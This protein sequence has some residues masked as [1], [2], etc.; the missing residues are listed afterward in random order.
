M[1]CYFRSFGTVGNAATTTHPPAAAAYVTRLASEYKR[2]FAE[3]RRLSKSI[4]HRMATLSSN[5]AVLHQFYHTFCICATCHGIYHT[6]YEETLIIRTPPL[7]PTTATTDDAA[8]QTARS[9]TEEE[10]C[11]RQDTTAPQFMCIHCWN[12]RAR[13]QQDE[14]PQPPQHQTQT[15]QQKDN[16]IDPVIIQNHPHA[17]TRSTL[18]K[19]N[20]IPT[21][22][23]TR[24][25]ELSASSGVRS[26]KKPGRPSLLLSSSL[27]S[28]ELQTTTPATMNSQPKSCVP[29]LVR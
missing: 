25:Q 1:C 2:A 4:Q 22:T 24:L 15:Q 6:D 27:S 21:T 23:V 19:E 10:G 11:S 18:Q 3:N 8:A 20:T 29:F 12:S 26:H 9:T 7:R 13:R 14:D 28:L 16:T 17:S 5:N